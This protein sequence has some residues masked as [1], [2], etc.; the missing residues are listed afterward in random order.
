LRATET[1]SDDRATAAL[2]PAVVHVD[3]D[4]ASDIYRVRGLPHPYAN[5]RVFETGLQNTLD[6]LDENRIRA[7]L[8]VI[9]DSLDNPQK[10]ALVREGQRRGHEIASHSLTHPSFTRLSAAEKRVE[11]RDSRA[12]LEDALGVRVRGFR[13]PGCEIDRE[14]ICALEEAGYEYDSSASPLPHF[15]KMLAVPI[16]SLVHP[17]RPFSGVSLVELP[18]PDHRPLPYP[19]RPSYSILFGRTY[20]S[21]GVRIARR[22]DAPYVLLLHLTDLSEPIE[23][24][25]HH[26][27]TTRIFTLSI[28]DHSRKRTKCQAMIDRVRREFVFSTT[29]QVL[30]TLSQRGA[31]AGDSGRAWTAE[32]RP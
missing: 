13:A 14:T 7:T 17:G 3:L 12:K 21:L 31:P 4:G 22:T 19:T 5:D 25:R 29:E 23:S 9:A 8:F 32:L 6:L 11:V 20:F 10:L 27:L 15:A 16:E 24:D 1:R 30:A 18:L 26:G 2:P 28:F